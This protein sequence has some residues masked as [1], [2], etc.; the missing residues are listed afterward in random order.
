MGYFSD[1]FKSDDAPVEGD[2][3][4]QTSIGVPRADDPNAVPVGTTADG[5][6][7]VGGVKYKPDPFNP[8][9]FAEGSFDDAKASFMDAGKI[10]VD[11]N[12]PALLTAAKRVSDYVKDM[13]FASLSAA[14]AALK[15]GIGTVAELIP[16]SENSEKRFERDMYG[17]LESTMGYGRAANTIDDVI[18]AS[19]KWFKSV[20][21]PEY[22]PTVMSANFGAVGINP[23]LR[24]GEGLRHYDMTDVANLDKAVGD[25]S[26]I[27]S[28]RGPSVD[29]LTLGATPEAG[30]LVALRPNL[31]SSIPDNPLNIPPRGPKAGETKL[32]TIHGPKSS[33]DPNGKVLSYRP[34]AVVENGE[35]FVDQNTR[36]KIASKAA[37]LDVPDA[38][39]KSP[40]MAV[41]GE[42]NPNRNLLEEGVPVTEIGVNPTTGHLFI[43]MKTGQAVK[44]HE[45]AMTIG[46]RVYATGVTYWNK[47]DAPEAQLASNGE[48]LPN[49]VTYKFDNAADEAAD[50]Q[51]NELFGMGHNQGPPLT[52]KLE[53]VLSSRTSEMALKKSDRI[54]PDNQPYF[55][56]TEADY[57]S[58]MIPQSPVYVPRNPDP[59]KKLPK[60]DRARAVI[61]MEDQIATKLSDRMKQHKNNPEIRYFY[62]MGPVIEKAKKMGYTEEYVRE[63]LTEFAE[64][65]A[66]TSPRTVTDQNLRNA[67]LVMA[68]RE[69]GIP[70]DE[71]VGDGTGG[72]NEKGFPMMIG[73]SGI[74]KRLVDATENGGINPDTNTKPYTFAENVKGNFDG[75]TIDTHAIRGALDAMN[76]IQQGSIPIGYIKPKW[77]EAYQNDPSQFDAATWLDDSMASQ[78]IDGQSMQTEYAVFSDVYKNAANKA[79]VSMAEAQALGWFGSGSSTGLMSEIKSI[80]T[81]LSDRISVTSQNLRGFSKD[82]VF[83]MMMDRKIPLLSI[84]GGTGIASV[85]YEE[86]FASQQGYQ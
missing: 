49:S 33:N 22:D 75:A 38:E 52:A 85:G 27:K 42:Y 17:M 86:G 73:E 39:N 64:A 51:S 45:A 6:E 58:N 83:R 80:P 29:K 9:K 62:H 7:Y 81:L 53:D 66:A 4:E 14:D 25:Y 50:A 30:T 36:R 1:I 57:K 68:K 23:S 31:N 46:D 70:L 74:H 59:T 69:A 24:Y 35:F 84:A 63:W 11:P 44:S 5:E 61:A 12:D 67:T 56:N 65:Y 34:Y 15:A 21:T 43:D 32:T 26:T 8:L 79:G 40:A 41:T 37:K 82:E 71:V 60:G 72:L 19:A 48:K 78:K 77:K 54:Q 20:P 3:L 16:Q 28:G 47:A 55:G 10:E 2:D 18:E 13:G 76:E